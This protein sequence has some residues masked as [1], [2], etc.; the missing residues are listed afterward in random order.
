[1]VHSMIDKTTNPS[2]NT[3]KVVVQPRAAGFKV[4]FLTIK[5]PQNGQMMG[6]KDG[7]DAVNLRLTKIGELYSKQHKLCKQLFSIFN[8][9]LK[10]V[11]RTPFVKKLTL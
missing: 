9:L 8:W 10:K 2:C 11:N 1:M 5:R 6:I 4:L 7:K 3:V